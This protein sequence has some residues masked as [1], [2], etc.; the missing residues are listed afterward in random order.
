L[1]PL[2][3]LSSWLIHQLMQF[4]VYSKS[5]LR[6]FPS[7]DSPLFSSLVDSLLPLP[8]VPKLPVGFLTGLV[9]TVYFFGHSIT[10]HKFYPIWIV[11]SSR[12]ALIPSP[13]CPPPLS[14]RR[15]SSRVSL[16]PNV[17]HALPS[18]LPALP[19][20]NVV[21]T[22]TQVSPSNCSPEFAR[23]GLTP[24]HPRTGPGFN[25]NLKIV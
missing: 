9:P 8:A 22:K 5:S 4:R 19:L 11:W 18:I 14:H 10:A 21:S 17:G 25:L 2:Q 12:S 7:S 6:S 15:N 16:F 24:L 3:K 13:L 1:G 23:K 20:D